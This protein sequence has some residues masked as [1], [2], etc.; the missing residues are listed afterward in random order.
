[1]PFEKFSRSYFGSNYEKARKNY[2][3]AVDREKSKFE[4]EYPDADVNDFLFHADLNESGDVVRSFTKYKNENAELFEITGYL[5]KKNYADTLYWKPRLWGTEGS[6]QPFVKNSS[7]LNVNSFKIYV[8]NEFV[9]RCKF[10]EI[11]NK[12]KR[13][14]ERL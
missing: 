10:P 14:L 12:K 5:F 8:T 4:K 9:L 6:I 2:E 11:G 1:M 13:K 7:D 3:S